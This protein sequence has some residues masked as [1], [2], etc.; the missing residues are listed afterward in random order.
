MYISK[1]Y[2]KF[3]IK[4][5]INNIFGNYWRQVIMIVYDNHCFLQFTE[6]KTF[7]KCLK[8]INKSNF[9]VIADFGYSQF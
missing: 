3:L 9:F 7:N 6:T 8:Y 5:V 1:Y 4:N 2:I